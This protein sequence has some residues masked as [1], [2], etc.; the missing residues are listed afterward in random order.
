MTH[1]VTHEYQPNIKRRLFHQNSQQVPNYMNRRHA[2][3]CSR[4]VRLPKPRLNYI[5]LPT[6]FRYMWCWTM[7]IKV[8]CPLQP[9]L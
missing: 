7:F 5:Y 8:D 4:R 3:V 1:F 2:C 9:P 6:L